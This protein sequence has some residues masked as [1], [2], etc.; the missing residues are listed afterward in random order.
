M[1]A[2]LLLWITDAP[3][4]PPEPVQWALWQILLAAAGALVT[5]SG[6]SGVLWWLVKP[7]VEKWATTILRQVSETHKSV[8]VNGGRNSPPTLRDDISRLGSQVQQLT[9][10]VGATAQRAS[11]LGDQIDLVADLARDNRDDLRAHIEHGEQYLGRVQ[12]VLKDKG[13]ELPRVE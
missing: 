4:P 12:L 8:T 1:L 13:I 2:P 6:A 9:V 5:I 3:S 11:D 10:A 7:R